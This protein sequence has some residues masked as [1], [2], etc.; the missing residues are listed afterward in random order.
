MIEINFNKVNKTYGFNKVLNNIDLTVKSREKIGLIGPNGSGKTTILKLIAGIEIPSSGV[1]SLRKG[2]TLGYLSQIPE[3]SDIKVKDYIYSTFSEILKVKK[4]L[5][6]YDISDNYKNINKY[7]KLQEKFMNMGVYALLAV[8][9]FC[10]SFKKRNFGLRE[11]ALIV[12]LM[13]CTTFISPTDALYRY[14][15]P[16]MCATPILF[17]GIA[18]LKNR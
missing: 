11:S 9:V 6:N 1:I 5:D 18:S 16:V 4:E 17:A 12:L 8:F 14:V 2:I 15:L 13:L 10:L 7:I 3:E